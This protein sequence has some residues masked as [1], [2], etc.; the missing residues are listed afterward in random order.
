MVAYGEEVGDAFGVDASGRV[1]VKL[2]CK[3]QRECTWEGGGCRTMSSLLGCCEFFLGCDWSVF[4]VGRQLQFFT[5]DVLSNG[6][7]LPL[8]I[9]FASSVETLAFFRVQYYL[10]YTFCLSPIS[11]VRFE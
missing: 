2:E 9:F 4:L 8:F 6:S 3:R 1:I 11:L 5:I 10:F 7:A